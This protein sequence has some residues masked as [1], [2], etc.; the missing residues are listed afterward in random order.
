LAYAI[1][2]RGDAK[3]LLAS[4][5]DERPQIIADTV[6]QMSDKLTKFTM[7][8]PVWIKKIAIGVMARM[9]RERGIQRK[10]CRNA[11]MLTGRYTKSPLID[12]RH[13]LAGRRIDDLVLPNGFAHQSRPRAGK[14][15][16]IAVGKSTSTASPRC[17]FP[18]RQ[19]VG[20]SNPR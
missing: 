20:S 3:L 10:V 6:D 11:G 8:T 17:A 1:Q 9:L 2:N 12:S 4:Y 13:P 16:L 5:N 7:Q 14:A 15:I 18:C 19:S